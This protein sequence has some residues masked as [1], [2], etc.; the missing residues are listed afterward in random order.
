MRVSRLL[1]R[2]LV[3]L[4]VRMPVISR[5]PVLGFVLVLLPVRS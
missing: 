1:V 5:V 2:V 3:L 4:R